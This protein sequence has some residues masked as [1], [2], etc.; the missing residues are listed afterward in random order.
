MKREPC[1]PFV[2]PGKEN[3]EMGLRGQPAPKEMAEKEEENQLQ[4]RGPVF[5]PW[6]GKIP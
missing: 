6:V 5:D 3:P 1:Q 2:E 4:C